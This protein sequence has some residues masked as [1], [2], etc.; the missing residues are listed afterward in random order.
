MIKWTK[1]G[2]TV[3]QEGTTITYEA[4]DHPITI[5][6]RKRHIPH[7]NGIG[8]WDHT[9]YFVIFLGKEVAEKYSLKDAKEY[10]EELLYGK[11]QGHHQTS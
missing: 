3:S 11:D 4:V 8:T 2:K 1:M 9:S 10:A 7:A 6:S 5:E